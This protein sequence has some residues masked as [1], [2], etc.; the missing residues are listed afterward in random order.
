MW[1]IS[2]PDRVNAEL[3]SRYNIVLTASASFAEELRAM[4]GTP[5]HALH[6]ATDPERFRPESGGPRHDLLFVGNSR[7][8]RRRIL[9][10]LLPTS[11]DMAVYG[12]DWTPDLLDTR[13][14]RGELIPNRDL[15]R[16]YAA[17][18]IVLNDHWDDMRQ[19]RFFSN[20]LYDALASGA[21]VISDHVEGI[22]EQFDGGVVTYRSRDDLHTK[23][24]HYLSNPDARRE[25][26]A[27]GHAAVLARHTFGAR[28]RELLAIVRP[29][30]E[31]RALGVTPL[32]DSRLADSRT[33]ETTR[34]RSA[35]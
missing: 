23:I 34:Y 19:H 10:D 14:V 7:K 8:T 3:C 9:D 11:H 22:K 31:G 18:D 2:H 33:G 25:V 6:Q 1:N 4:S 21:F 24:G 15:H 5:V 20:R 35:S 12:R 32:P 27:R 13:Y 30:L 29:A 28:V 16:Y 26:A 17:A